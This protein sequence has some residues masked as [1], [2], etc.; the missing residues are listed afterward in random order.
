MVALVEREVVGRRVWD[1]DGECLWTLLAQ[2]TI[3]ASI[4]SPQALIY[5]SALLARNEN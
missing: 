3:L 4:V 5:R 1:Q 2:P